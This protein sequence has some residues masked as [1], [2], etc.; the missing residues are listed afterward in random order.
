[1]INKIELNLAG[2]IKFSQKSTQLNA[3]QEPFNKLPY[4]DLR[5]R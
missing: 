1:M 5:R 2:S 3:F 4:P